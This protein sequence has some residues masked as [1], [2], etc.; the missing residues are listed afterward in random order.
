MNRDNG[1]RS[2]V[3]MVF[4]WLKG[5]VLAFV[6]LL[7]LTAA[8]PPD[9]KSTGGQT[10]FDQAL[11]HWGAG[12]V[13]HLSG[14][15]ETAIEFFRKSIEIHP[16]ARGHTFL[17]WSLSMLGRLEEAIAECKKAV[18]LDPDYGNPYNDIG[19]YL[20]EL[21]RPDEAIPWLEKAMTAKRYCC[22][23]Y[24]HVNMGRI[25]LDKGRLA[26]AQQAFERALGYDPAYPPALKGLDIIRRLEFEPL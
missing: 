25:L 18:P 4:R 7:W 24:A 5:C 17:G 11:A 14:R 21:G 22:Y 9:G 23:Q 19:L 12:Y 20:I 10:P 1:G 8:A 2:G 26:E 6:C 13:Y 16:T 15:F 3:R